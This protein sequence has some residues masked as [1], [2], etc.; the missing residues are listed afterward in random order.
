LQPDRDHASAMFVDFADA[1]F[2]VLHCNPGRVL[3]VEI[4]R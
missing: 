1:I 2:S 4:D 3:L